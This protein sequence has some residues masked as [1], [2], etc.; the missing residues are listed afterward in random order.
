MKSN[1]TDVWKEKVEKK[2]GFLFRR[3]NWRSKE[4]RA[5]EVQLLD[6]LFMFR[7]YIFY[8]LLFTGAWYKNG[9]HDTESQRS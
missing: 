7:L 4:V 8:F 1:E 5:A 6:S 2:F 9:R 3:T